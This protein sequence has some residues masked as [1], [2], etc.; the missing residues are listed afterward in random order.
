MAINLNS[1]TPIYQ[2][3]VEHI[4][5]AIAS[6]LYR[7]GEALPSV[8]VLA[9]ELLVNPNTVQKAF[10]EL[11]RSGLVVARKG[12]G[13]FVADGCA[14]S[15]RS[16]AQTAIRSLLAQAIAASRLAGLPEDKIQALF[17]AELNRPRSGRKRTDD[18]SK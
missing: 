1:H 11:E 8:R 14:A 17:E 12:V 6:G 5:T 7:S 18:K 2:Q 9:V 4:R 13:F 3:I 16:G 10:D 15:A